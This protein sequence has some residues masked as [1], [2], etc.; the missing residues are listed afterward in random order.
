MVY[1]QTS[2][3]FYDTLEKAKKQCKSQELTIVMGDLNAKV[4]KDQD[5]SNGMVGKHG[6][7]TRNER[8]DRWEQWCAAHN[9]VITN[10][11]FEEHPRRLWKW[12]SPCSDVNNRI[13]YIT[14]NNRFRTAV[15]Q[16][17][18]YPGANSGSDHIPVICKLRIKLMKLKQ[19]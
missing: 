10:T 18:A 2:T 16:A 15:R 7:V 19:A 9:Q 5:G 1:A 12:R 17:K 14:I 11:C 13:D 6:L 4:G 3:K 8:G